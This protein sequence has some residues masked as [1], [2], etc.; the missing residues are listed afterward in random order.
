MSLSRGLAAI[1]LEPTDKIPHTQQVS[2]DEYLLKMTGVDTRDLSQQERA[3]PALAA[4]LDYDFIWNICEMP[5][6]R[7]RQTKM[8]HAVWS[9][10]DRMDTETFC[11]FKTEEDVYTFDPVAEYGIPDHDDTVRFFRGHVAKSRV[12]Y[13]EA[14]LPAGRYHSLFSACIRSF[15][16]EMFLASVPNHERE[17]D[18]VLEGFLEMSMAE[19]KAWL[20]TD[21]KV[22]TCHDDIAWTSGAVFHPD[23]YR[24]Y[25][26]P[27]Y[28]RLWAP[29][30]EKGVKVI[31]CADGTFTEFVDDIAEA[32]AD[33]F[34]FEPTTSLE[35]ITEK[36]GQ[37]KII[38][39]NMDCRVLMFGTKEA[40]RADVKRI[41]DLGRPCPGYFMYMGNMIPNGIPLENV[42]YF[43]EVFEE[44]RG[45]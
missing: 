44:L 32:G 12:L 18:R 21:I 27:K 5:V 33:G 13:P 19:V 9:E 15:G 35:Y 41:L 26:F 10:T 3:L 34:I 8:G 42:E 39:G 43:F 20:E 28:R 6:T 1:N 22:Y 11:P 36:Y 23:W 38:I 17:F 29:L 2:H 45:R 40:I 14:V 25:I 7:G 4:L 31:F 30:K 24:K 16:W 37:S